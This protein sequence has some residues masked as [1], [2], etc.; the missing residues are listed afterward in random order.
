MGGRNLVWV[1]R[2]ARSTGFFHGKIALVIAA[3][4]ACAAAW[5]AP[6]PSTPPPAPPA[7]STPP[8][9]APAAE[10]AAPADKAGTIPPQYSELVKRLAKLLPEAA[11]QSVRPSGVEGVVE[12]LLAGNRIVYCD[13]AGK[14]LFNGH[15][16]E[17][18]THE[19][20]TERRLGEVNRIDPKQLP[21][22]DAFDVKR[23]NGKRELYLFEDPDC[24]YCRK[25]E[26]QLPKINDVTLHVFLYP[27]TS[28]HP[29]ALEHSLGVWCSKDRQ[30]AWSDKM[31]K[32]IDPAV[33]TC[34]NPI[35]RNLA[36]GDKL[37][38]EGTPT[39]IFPD[40]RVHEGTL[41]AD[42]L[43]HLLAGGG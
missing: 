39:L 12:V 30:K 42:E 5:P 16:F 6:A 4:A 20:L 17:L 8:P 25:F 31:L 1:E 28:I 29:H 14:H 24:P 43:E 33:A 11:V 21:L 10:A 41:E 3:A 13:L 38:I 15:L 27:L 7:A 37:H 23:G 19:D 40:G 32:G 22:A 34:D 2:A 26:E 9:V 35:D 18:E 36:L